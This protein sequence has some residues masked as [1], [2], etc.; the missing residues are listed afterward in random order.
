MIGDNVIF[1]DAYI[2]YV[3][4]CITDKEIPLFFKDWIRQLASWAK[5]QNE[6]I[7]KKT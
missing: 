5:E 7:Q 3:E 1:K 2:D 4:A 6:N